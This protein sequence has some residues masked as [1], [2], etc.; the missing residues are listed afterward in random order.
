MTFNKFL[1]ITAIASVFASLF[2]PFIV[3]NN[4]F[5]PFITGKAFVWRLFVE[6]GATAWILLILRD[7][8]ARPRK[9][10]ILWAFVAFTVIIGIA[11]LFGA[12]AWKSFWSNFERMEGYITILHLFAY[13]IVAGSVLATEK[14]WQRFLEWSAGTSAAV[15]IYSV[16]QLAGL[17]V[18]N[19]GGVRVDAT[20]GN[21]AYLA[22]YLVFNIFFALILLARSAQVWK[23]VMYGVLAA[24]H[25]I[26]LYYTATRG[27]ILGLLGGLALSAL[28]V[29]LFGK[30]EG[31][32]RNRIIAGSVLGFLVVI[33][34]GFVAIKNTSFVTNSPVL[35]RF[36][37]ISWNE[38]KTQA[39]GYIWPMAIKGFEEHPILGWGQENFN[40]VFNA[41]YD[42]RMY[43]QEQWFDRAHN[44]V[45]DWL[46]A[47]G[48]L[49]LLAYL[50]LFVLGI[51]LLWKKSSDTSLVEKSLLTGLGTAYLFHNLF[52]FDNIASYILFASWLA[53]IHFK[54]TRL[55]LPIGA[56][57]EGLDQGES[58]TATPIALVVLVFIIYFFEWRAYATCTALIDALKAV[59][60]SP[61]QADAAL[62][63]FTRAASYGTLG[64]ME[65]LERVVEAVPKMN[66]Q[67]ISL[68]T[69]QKFYD[70]GNNLIKAEV[71]AQPNDARLEVFA[72]NFYSFYGQA[73]IAESHLVAAEKLSP[74]KQTIL[75]QLGSF[76][77][78]AKQYDKALAA[79]K[80]AAELDP[81]YTDSYKFY[82]IALVYAGRESEAKQL[83]L[84]KF[85]SSDMTDDS[86]LQVYANMGQWSR[87]ITILN[88]R[89]AVDPKNTENRR[90]L[91]AA[92]VQSGNITAAIKAVRDLIAVEPGF[93]ATGEEYIKQ[94]QAGTIK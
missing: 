92:Y 13:F 83:M 69:R 17:L 31:R 87:V 1:R 62:D 53:F 72:G 48:A 57:A 22:V 89:I 90:N 44:V 58:R 84:Q 30:G 40:Y 61:V 41:N 82:A 43:R 3:A 39:R 68:D 16:L 8:S 27:S 64:R 21:A 12:N 55:S 76:Y 66:T 91:I 93:A 59:S 35:S 24:L 50:S 45:L 75:F 74:T 28:L 14:L 4:L 10:L 25:V 85:G 23:K 63:G 56:Q 18:I 33:V 49:G 42:P 15:S 19:Q 7:A 71:A 70:L 60:V 67:D 77:L 52:V 9:S 78:T 88:A 20:F 73:E 94:L 37:S 26:I 54:S 11:D 29:A 38:T 79:F 80:Q 65:V 32:K 2:I 34:L 5:F 36:A 81:T 86:F 46:I 47:G 51:Y 6:I